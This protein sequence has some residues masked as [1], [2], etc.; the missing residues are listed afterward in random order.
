MKDFSKYQVQ[1]NTKISVELAAWLDEY[2]QKTGITK[3]EII[4]EALEDYRRK[5]EEQ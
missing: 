3:V 5:K 2:S 4:K 1:F